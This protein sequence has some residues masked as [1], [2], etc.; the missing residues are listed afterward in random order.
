MEMCKKMV[1]FC[2]REVYN[3]IKNRGKGK[4][5]KISDRCNRQASCSLSD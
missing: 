4:D 5:A 1:V 2:D 3:E